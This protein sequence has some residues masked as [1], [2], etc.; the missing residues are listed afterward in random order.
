MR[1][2][3]ASNIRL[4]SLTL[5]C[6][7]L[8]RWAGGWCHCL[9]SQNLCLQ[10]AGL[11]PCQV[12]GVMAKALCEN[13]AGEQ[14]KMIEL[15][16]SMYTS[17]SLGGWLCNCLRSDHKKGALRKSVAET[18]ITV[19]GSTLKKQCWQAVAVYHVFASLFKRD[20][21]FH[22]HISSRKTWW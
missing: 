2:K 10:S 17:V 14:H 19:K 18:P 12:Q 7:Y 6:I 15:G 8:S 20:S 5:P 21:L 9:F 16:A 1:T 22:I 4:S 13:K 3:R 11:G